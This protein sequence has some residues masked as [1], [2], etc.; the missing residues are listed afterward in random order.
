MSRVEGG[1]IMVEL[2]MEDNGNGVDDL[3]CSVIGR[4]II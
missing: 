2:D 4:G 1:N 3:K